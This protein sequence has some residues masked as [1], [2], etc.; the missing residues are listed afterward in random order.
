VEVENN[1]MFEVMTL[2]S[3]KEMLQ[4]YLAWPS[5]NIYVIV[6]CSLNIVDACS[7]PPN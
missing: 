5:F 7:Q 4:C 3:Q 6:F 2:I 1:Y